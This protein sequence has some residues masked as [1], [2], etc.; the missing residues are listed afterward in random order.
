MSA[1]VQV[2]VDDEGAVAVKVAST[3]TEVAR[4][5]REAERLGR[6][7]HPGVVTLLGLTTAADRAEL[8]T[9]FGGEP[10][11]RWRGSLACVAGLGAAVA[12]TL[13]DL[14]A[15]GLVHGRID[16]SHIVVGADGRPRLC[17][18]AGRDGTTAADDV[19]ALAHVL[20][21]LA[22]TAT[23]TRRRAGAE[24]RALA[25]AL[26]D[27]RDAVPERRPDA[28]TLAGALLAA[29]PGADL[30]GAPAPS[31]LPIRS[32]ARR[33]VRTTPMRGAKPD[34]EPEDAMPATSAFD[35][36]WSA[37][38]DLDRFD[39]EPWPPI[40]DPAGDL[41]TD[42]TDGLTAHHPSGH[43]TSPDGLGGPV[44]T[45]EGMRRRRPPETSERSVRA[46]LPS[47][48]QPL[49][50]PHEETGPSGRP[51]RRIDPLVAAA[52]A[53]LVL[54]AGGAAVAVALT[55]D[56]GGDREAAAASRG[57][58]SGG[59]ALPDAGCAPVPPPA[60]DIDGD[61]CPEPVHVDGR[62]VAA[63]D[64]RWTLG[65]PGDLVAIGDW[66]CD[67]G[68]TPALLRPVTGEVFVFPAWAPDG[69]PLTVTATHRVVDG[70]DIHADPGG[71]RCDTLLVELATG[72]TTA[73]DVREE[74]GR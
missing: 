38:A 18:L 1:R 44:P 17:G 57:P 74:D 51:R 70:V 43:P 20:D 59:D 31:R 4:L 3:D 29:V 39:D 58:W 49:V 68:A 60:A 15:L 11:D 62:T 34:A 10:L 37:D 2:A 67:G 63:G 12:T 55:G 26:R 53:A 69:A 6:A 56:G 66:N 8:R 46:L 19:A 25:E 65:E 22:A 13:A 35:T 45:R 54:A 47:G 50:D 73:V 27:A 21:D 36:F 71:D 16:A 64:A 14:H 24:R 32:S 23:P 40:G 30:P 7:C 5:H 72:G 61:G 48:R 28:A 33:P 9:R 42:P 52:G 41:T